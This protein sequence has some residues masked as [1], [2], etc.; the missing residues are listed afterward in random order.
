MAEPYARRVQ[1]IRRDSGIMPREEV[2]RRRNDMLMQAGLNV[3]QQ[4]I[5]AL[6]GGLLKS[7]GF[8][9]ATTPDR[10]LR[11]EAAKRALERRFIRAQGGLVENQAAQI[12]YTTVD[13]MYKSRINPYMVEGGKN[14]RHQQ[15]LLSAEKIARIKKGKGGG[16]SG[17]KGWQVVTDQSGRTFLYDRRDLI[18][19]RKE[20]LKAISKWSEGSDDRIK[21]NERLAW[22]TNAISGR[23]ISSKAAEKKYGENWV[24]THARETAM[25]G[26]PGTGTTPGNVA[27][28]IKAEMDAMSKGNM[29]VTDKHGDTFDLSPSQVRSL[30]SVTEAALG[31]HKIETTRV[32]TTVDGEFEWQEVSFEKPALYWSNLNEASLKELRD[33]RKAYAKLQK[34]HGDSLEA[35]T[36]RQ[37]SIP[38]S[39]FDAGEAPATPT[40]TKKKVSGRDITIKTVS[41]QVKLYNEAKANVGG[42]NNPKDDAALRQ[43]RADLE[44]VVKQFNDETYELHGG[45][46]LELK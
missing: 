2:E 8:R 17:S 29:L 6:T 36:G 37:R 31:D 3:A 26:M 10:M 12:P 25:G 39:G 15:G 21:A 14:W 1:Q 45:L 13:N 20:L 33:K 32:K 44:P 42:K 22:L 38:G 46:V 30:L 4:G 28:A 19:Q 27:S 5:G 23:P 35:E 16:G 24:E 41:R 40:P 7:E 43:W 34:E 18:R 11:E 9:Q